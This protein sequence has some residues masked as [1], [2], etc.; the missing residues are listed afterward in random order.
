MEVERLH[1]DK[2]QFKLVVL[3][4]DSWKEPFHAGQADD[5][6]D[7]THSTSGTQLSPPFLVPVQSTCTIS[8]V[9]NAIPPLCLKRAL[10][11][12]KCGNLK[13]LNCGELNMS[14]DWCAAVDIISAIEF[15]KSGEHLATGDRGGRV[16]LFERTDSREVR[17][18]S[19]PSSDLV[20]MGFTT[21]WVYIYSSTRLLMLSNGFHMAATSTKG[22]GKGRFGGS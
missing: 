12:M 11:Q 20:E 7:A 22:V 6:V 21:S 1:R 2:P 16:V 14:L 10:E 8:N 19:L 5:N 17:H 9:Q 18:P 3:H 13:M 15:D 4:A